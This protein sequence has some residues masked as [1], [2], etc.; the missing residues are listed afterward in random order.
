MKHSH[1]Q[2]AGA[3]ISCACP[4][5]DNQ[6]PI[7]TC[8]CVDSLTKSQNSYR[9]VPIW[10][11][12]VIIEQFRHLKSSNVIYSLVKK[13]SDCHIKGYRIGWMESKRER[14][15]VSRPQVG[16]LGGRSRLDAGI[17]ANAGWAAAPARSLAND[18]DLPGSDARVR[19][20]RP[21]DV[22]RGADGD[23]RQLPDMNWVAPSTATV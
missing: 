2:T 19:H 1:D 4:V 13:P 15:A 23:S 7:R 11:T 5:P 10:S 9:N 21:A 12:I 22:H 3:S 8:N 17:G 20:E 6:P 14:P 16:A 18:R